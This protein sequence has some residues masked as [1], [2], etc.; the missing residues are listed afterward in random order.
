[1]G[2]VIPEGAPADMIGGYDV[3]AM[4]REDA[5]FQALRAGP[6]G[7]HV[8]ALEADGFAVWIQ[9][10]WPG[11]GSN[12]Y[13]FIASGSDGQGDDNRFVVC[14]GLLVEGCIVDASARLASGPMEARVKTV[15][16]G[17][18]GEVVE[19]AIAQVAQSWAS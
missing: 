2:S 7:Q 12:G 15:F 14:G 10:A 5:A 18:F 19:W 6:D 13:E 4:E 1:M 17:T 11:D 16:T 3:D 8:E 9:D